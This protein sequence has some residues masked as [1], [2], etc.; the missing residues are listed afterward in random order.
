MAIIK[1]IYNIPLRREFQ[2]SPVYKKS[3][4]AITGLIIFLKKHMKSEDVKIGPKLNEKIWENGIRNPPHH[5]EVAVLK[6]EEGQ[7]RAELVGFEKDFLEPTNIEEKNSSKTDVVKEKE[8]KAKKTTV[9]TESIE[10]AIEKE[11]VKETSSLKTEDVE[12]VE[13]KP[14][15]TVKAD[16]KKE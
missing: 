5:V 15:K 3:K 8:T 10:E 6:N 14:S 13:K 12:K 2:K 1:R 11:T 7:V 16:D 4:K 9:K